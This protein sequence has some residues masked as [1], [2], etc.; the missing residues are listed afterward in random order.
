MGIKNKLMRPLMCLMLM[1][2]AL[3]INR[4]MSGAYKVGSLYLSGQKEAAIALAHDQ[5]A[6]TSVM[7]AIIGLIVAVVLI[8]AVAIP[9]I[10]DLTA[11]LTGTTATVV[12]V[13][14]IALAVGLLIMAF[15]WFR[16]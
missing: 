9:V 14:P 13:V 7:G 8:S 12:N 15:S 16:A 1:L 10:Q 2:V 5:R 4:G 3:P 6:S 11:N